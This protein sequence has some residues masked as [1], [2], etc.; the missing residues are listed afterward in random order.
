M[1]SASNSVS[2]STS[3][4]SSSMEATSTATASTSP[5]GLKRIAEPGGICVS[6]VVRDQQVRDKLADR[7]RGSWASSSSRTSPARCGSSKSDAPALAG[8]EPRSR[9]PRPAAR[10]TR[11]AH[12][13]GP[14]VPEHERRPG[15]GILRRRYGRRHHHRV[16]TFKSLFGIADESTLLQGPARHK[17]LAASSACVMCSKVA[18][19]RLAT[20]CGSPAQLIDATSGAHVWAERYD[21]ALDDIFALQDELTLSVIGAIEPSLRRV[22]IE[23][24]RRKRPDSLDA[25]DLYLRA[26]PVC[27]NGDA[28]G[29]RQGVAAAR[30]G[31][32]PGA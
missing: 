20:E 21:R 5:P 1:N 25:W 11:Q 23:R 31:D 2:A 28:R 16:V 13:R 9:L 17:Q 27:G 8:I 15:T 7:V 32:R 26:L 29:C 3:A 14:A 22:E 10:P 6:C 19:A 30:T 18:Y 24:A 12:D 4:T